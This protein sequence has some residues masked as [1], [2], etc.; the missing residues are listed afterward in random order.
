MMSSLDE[1]DFDRIGF[2]FSLFCLSKI[3]NTT[4]Q[5]YLQEFKEFFH[6]TLLDK[7]E[8]EL[9]IGADELV[10]HQPKSDIEREIDK[11]TR[12]V[13]VD[14]DMWIKTLRLDKDSWKELVQVIVE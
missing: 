9:P 4:L 14:L 12:S 8:R 6:E 2:S 13:E 1:A 11:V 5:K 7:S 10:N 3:P